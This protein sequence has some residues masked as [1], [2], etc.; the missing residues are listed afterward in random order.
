[1]MLLLQYFL[2]LSLLFSG[3]VLA[4]PL[5]QEEQG[6]ASFVV[7][8]IRNRDHTPH[9]PTALRRAYKKFN[10][11]STNFGLNFLDFKRSRT[12]QP[13]RASNGTDGAVQATSISYGLEYVS[14]VAIGGQNV[15]MNFDTGSADL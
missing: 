4:L 8:R 12:G 6:G 11:R 1:M 13:R 15:R 9:G 5:Q 3:I 2:S 10:I 7:N 14:T